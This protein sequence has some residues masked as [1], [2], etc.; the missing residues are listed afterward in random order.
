[1]R[2]K[3]NRRKW[4]AAYKLRTVKTAMQPGV[5]IC[6]LSRQ[7]GINVTQLY[8]R[9]KQLLGSAKAVF[10]QPKGRP[11]FVEQRHE[12]E[13]QRLR[14]VITEITAENLDL[15]N[16]SWASPD[17]SYLNITFRLLRRLTVYRNC[18]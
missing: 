18:S 16:G 4:S 1:M 9:K 15:K 10:D 14:L 13:L 8:N 6:D 11:K 12:V 5:E 2:E 17:Y 7:E 3:K